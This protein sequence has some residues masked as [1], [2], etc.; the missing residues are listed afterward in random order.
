MAIVWNSYTLCAH[1]ILA[2]VLL[3]SLR[4]LLLLL[5]DSVGGEEEEAATQEL[6]RVQTLSSQS[7]CCFPFVHVM[8]ARA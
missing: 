4:H 3:A 6:K 1:L 7:R 5:M 8:Q 2:H